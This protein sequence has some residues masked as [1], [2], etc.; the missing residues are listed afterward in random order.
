VSTVD[1]PFG[2]RSPAAPPAGAPP[3]AEFDD[4][5]DDHDGNSTRGQRA[6]AVVEYI[7]T[8]FADNPDAIDVETS[9]RGRND[10]MIYLHADRRDAGR[11]I[12]RRG[13]VINAIRQVARAAGSLDGER[14]QLDLAEE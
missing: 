9:D 13:R 4:D 1:D 5:L 8:S 14:V 6:A 7:A 11:L 2:A 12:G 10:V 3:A